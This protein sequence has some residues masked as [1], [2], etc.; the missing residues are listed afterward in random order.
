M[1]FNCRL[2]GPYPTPP[3]RDD[4]AIR[5][6][7]DIFQPENILGVVPSKPD[8]GSDEHVI[9]LKFAI[10]RTK[11]PGGQ[12]I[13]CSMCSE[14]HPKFL[15]GSLLW[16]RDGWLRVIGH[17]C[18]KKKRTSVRHAIESFSRNTSKR[19]LMKRLLIYLNSALR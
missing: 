4:P 11:R 15:A 13:P 17:V 18:A 7:M 19:S 5:A 12:F 16:S 10:D 6:G 9:V 3:S 14:N 1:S 2:T 8:L